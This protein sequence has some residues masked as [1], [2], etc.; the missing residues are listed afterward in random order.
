MHNIAH[1]R[2]EFIIIIKL[3]S[4]GHLIIVWK[5]EFMVLRNRVSVDEVNPT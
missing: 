1:H 2:A 4:T 3:D 5:S